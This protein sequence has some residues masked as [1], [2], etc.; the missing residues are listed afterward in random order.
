[1]THYQYIIVLLVWTIATFVIFPNVLSLDTDT[2]KTALKY[3]LYF[4]AFLIV[5]VGFVYLVMWFLYKYF[6]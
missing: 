3:S 1:M 5:F 4:E 2:Y 6:H